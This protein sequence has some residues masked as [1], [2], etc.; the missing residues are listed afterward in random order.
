MQISFDSGSS[1]EPETETEVHPTAASSP[2]ITK[3]TPLD[4]T[5]LSLALATSTTSEAT[6]KGMMERHRTAPK[7]RAEDEPSHESSQNGL[8]RPIGKNRSKTNFFACGCNSG[9]NNRFRDSEIKSTSPKRFSSTAPSSAG[10]TDLSEDSLEH[11]DEH[12]LPA[13]AGAES[14]QQCSS[15]DTRIDTATADSLSYHAALAA[16]LAHRSTQPIPRA[17]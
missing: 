9:A 7:L 10:T 17:W 11:V 15:A 8:R 16:R 3:D 12:V 4:S 14:V 6:Y 1:S 13:A 2:T 5:A